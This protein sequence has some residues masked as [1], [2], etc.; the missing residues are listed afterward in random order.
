MELSFTDRVAIITGAGGA[1]G[2]SHALELARRG[3]KVVVNDVGGSVH[4]EG[5]AMAP[6]QH[7][8]EEI[9]A[10]GGDAVANFDTVTTPGGGRAIVDCA[11]DNFGRLDILVNNAG[12]LRDR[13]FHNMGV[14]E[15]DAVIDVHLRG[16]MF[17]TQ[18]AFKIMR[19][20]RFGRIINTTSASGLFGNFGQ[21][22][23]GSAKAG[24]FG[25]TRVLAHEGSRVNI[26]VNA[27][28]PLAKT[29]MTDGLFGEL[30]DLLDPQWVS[31]VVAYLA[32]ESCAVNGY[33]YSV[34]AGRVARVFMAESAG[35]VLHEPSA[36]S[37]RDMLEPINSTADFLVPGSLMD[38]KDII[39]HAVKVSRG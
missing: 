19:E 26:C 31:A 21:A 30:E 39:E 33:V 2:R 18:P 15:I 6:A 9:K 35:R 5:S 36:E 25:L 20:Q 22:N 4:G 7:V 13:A 17:V 34:A 16:A 32:H 8:V 38:E 11:L 24:L 1:L 14:A 27:V 23:Y 10:L 28:A 3:A 29:R 37:F 12:I